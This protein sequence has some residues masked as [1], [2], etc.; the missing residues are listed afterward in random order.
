MQIRN[1]KLTTPT[2]A[3]LACLACSSTLAQE[4]RWF[5][6]EL[7]VFANQDP[8]AASAEKWNGIPELEYPMATRFLLD[9]ARVARNEGRYAGESVIDKYG[10]QIIKMVSGSRYDDTEAAGVPL[11]AT[12]AEPAPTPLT[13]VVSTPEPPAAPQALPRPFVILPEGYQTLR[14]KAAQMKR[15]G[16]YAVLFHETWVQPVGPESRSVPIVLDHSGDD[17]QWPRLQGTITLFLSRYLHLQTN[18]WLNTEGEYLPGTWHMPAP[19]FGPPSLIVE[20]E[21]R[22][23]IDAAIGQMPAQEDQQGP[24]TAANNS[25]MPAG[26][27]GIALEEEM[28]PVY[29]YRHAVLFE[30]TRRMRSNE[31]H[32]IDH[33]LMGAI[34]TFTPVTDQDLADIAAQQ[35]I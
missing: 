31:V 11:A 6:V 18:L 9:P 21:E 3:L 8:A 17:L 7:V 24:A 33:P 26:E 35:K 12:G 15:T 4:Y 32:Y 34:I 20:E 22:V 13:P 16:R 10:R 5:R 28:G 23:D 14:A 25:E 30:Q 2:L 29:P 27:V 19:P 1:L